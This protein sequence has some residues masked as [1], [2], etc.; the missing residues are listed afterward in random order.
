[1]NETSLSLL[2]QLQQTSDAEAWQRL[3]DLYE[4]ML[5]RWLGQYGVRSSDVDDILQEV[6]LAVSSE[7]ASFDHN[8]RT[9][10]FRSWL[11]ITLV[12]RL[13]NHW[14]A[15]RGR[16][17]TGNSDVERR[18]AQLEDPASALTEIWN[19]DHDRHVLSK[20]LERT[21]QSFSAS[22]WQAFCRTA[23]EGEAPN[24]VADQ[25]KLSLNAV[26]VAKSRVLGRLRQEAEGLVE[27]C[28]GFSGC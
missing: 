17:L 24:E 18:L 15:T 2:G 22:T 8:G 23:L 16:P 11:R 14:R 21:E 4:P 19:R 3:M 20:L 28:A 27:S 9:G 26:F 12:N 1:M 25:L 6:L 7:I 5:R 13:R 10:A